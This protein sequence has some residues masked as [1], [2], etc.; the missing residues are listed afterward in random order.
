MSR[1][2]ELGAVASMQAL[3]V[4]TQREGPDI[5]AKVSIQGFR[6]Q[7]LVLLDPSR[8]GASLRSSSRKEVGVWGPRLEPLL[9]RRSLSE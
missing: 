3:A 9:P 6:T 1:E 5:L 4:R 7:A 2:A 8:P